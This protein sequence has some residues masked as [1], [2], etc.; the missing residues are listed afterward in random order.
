MLRYRAIDIIPASLERCLLFIGT[1]TYDFL[2][3]N[4]AAMSLTKD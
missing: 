3:T 2:L 4:A 1:L